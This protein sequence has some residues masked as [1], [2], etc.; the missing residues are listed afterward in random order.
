MMPVLTIFIDGLKPES[1]EYMEFLSTFEHVKR[2]KTELGYSLVCHASMYTGVYPNKH[3]CWF[4][5]MYSPNTSPFRLIRRFYLDKFLNKFSNTYL[6]YLCYKTCLSLNYVKSSFGFTVFANLIPMNYWNNFDVSVKKPLTDPNALVYPTIFDILRKNNIK[7]E[8]VGLEATN[9]AESSKVV[10]KHSLQDIKPWTYYFIGDIDPLSHKYGQDSFEVRKRLQVIDRIVEEKYKKFENKFNDDFYF[11]LFSDHGHTK[12]TNKVNLNVV[13]REN[14]KSL[15]DYIFFLDSN[16]ARFWFRNERERKEV[17]DILSK[18]DDKGFILTDKLLEKYHVNMPDNRYG[19]LI[20]YLDK[21][22]I[23]DHGEIIVFGKRL[24]QSPISMHGYLPDY[25]DSDGVFITNRR[26]INKSHIKL[27]DIAPS[28]LYAIGLD[29]PDYM[30]GEV[31][32][33]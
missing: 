6:K 22:N 19:D 24:L 14:G 30:D 27:E 15:K 29:V 16:Y 3:L 10:E 9:L 31:I 13:F 11:M 28:I 18:M 7:Y 5:W 1:V 2:V 26:V 4:T 8:I 12:V 17:E 21:P 33:R 20:F 25:T 23:F 32:W